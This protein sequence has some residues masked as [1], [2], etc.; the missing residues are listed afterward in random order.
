M[1]KLSVK[2][3]LSILLHVLL[4]AGLATGCTAKMVAQEPPTPTPE[5]FIPRTVVVPNGP[6]VSG[7][8][9][10]A[11]TPVAGARVELRTGAWADPNNSEAIAV[12]FAD[13]SG[14]YQLEAPPAGG[15]FGLVA[16]WPDGSANPAPVTPVQMVAGTD[17]TGAD[18]YLAKE[19]ELLEPISGAEV[20]A[21]PTLRWIGSPGVRAYTLQI[22][23]AG[24]TELVFD[25]AITEISPTMHLVAPPL[26]PD[27]TYRWM[28]N[29]WER[30]DGD[31]SASNLLAGLTSEFK[32]AP[33]AAVPTSEPMPAQ[34]IAVDGT[35][36][37]YTN[38]QLGFS[39]KFPQRI[40]SLYG[41]CT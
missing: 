3:A 11:S 37:Q 17:L 14:Q 30:D 27:R 2:N 12:T 40:V 36:N 20:E 9:L 6:M 39:I 18:V 23:D 4:A 7:R 41:S 5:V 29:G 26:T 16:L 22:V 13:S 19:L 1:F 38:H 33:Q 25:L 32:V 15:Q 21:T 34:I 35:W 10:W 8:V 24:T 28:V 31:S